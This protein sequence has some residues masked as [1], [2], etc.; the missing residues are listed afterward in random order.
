MIDNKSKEVNVKNYLDDQI[1]I[2][3]LDSKKIALDKKII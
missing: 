2:N 3:F 1:N